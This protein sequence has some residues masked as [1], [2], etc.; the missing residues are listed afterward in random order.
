MRKIFQLMLFLCIYPL[1]AQ[2]IGIHPWMLKYAELTQ[3]LTETE[4]DSKWDG[5]L[6]QR[7]KLL[8]SVYSHYDKRS[9]NDEVYPYL[10]LSLIRSYIGMGDGKSAVKI[11]TNALR[12]I[13]NKD[14]ALA[15]T[16]EQI[17][18]YI[19]NGD[20]DLAESLYQD[21]RPQIEEVLQFFDKNPE[22]IE[23]CNIICNYYNAQQELT[24]HY[25][26]ALNSYQE[27]QQYETGKDVLYNKKD[28]FTN[29]FFDF[30]TLQKINHIAERYGLSGLDLTSS[31][32]TNA[33]V[34]YYQQM[35][36]F[37]MKTG[38]YADASSYYYMAE[39]Y[40]DKEDI[41]SR[42]SIA[43]IYLLSARYLAQI[44][45]YQ[46][47]D[48]YYTKCI[49]ICANSDDKDSLDLMNYS[50]MELAE[51]KA[52]CGQFEEANDYMSMLMDYYGKKDMIATVDFINLLWHYNTVLSRARRYKESCDICQEALY[53]LPR[54]ADLDQNR[55]KT[56]FNNSLAASLSHLQK[57]NEAIECLNNI[58]PQYY[59]SNTY[60]TKAII[61][62][63]LG[64]YDDAI[65]S[66]YECLKSEEQDVPSDNRLSVYSALLATAIEA[67]KPID[68]HEIADLFMSLYASISEIS[69][70][71]D[72]HYLIPIYQI[73]YEMFLSYCRHFNVDIDVAYNQTLCFKGAILQSEA[74]MQNKIMLS[75]DDYV[76][77]RYNQIKQLEQRI[78]H[79]ISNHETQQL[80]SQVD[81][82]EKE[83]IHRLNSVEN[84]KMDVNWRAVSQGLTRNEVAIELVNYICPSESVEYAALILRK[85]W[86]APKMIPLCKKSDLEPLITRLQGIYNNRTHRDSAESYIYKRLYSFVWSKLEP[87]IN[88]GDNVYFSPSGLLHQL[89]IEVLKDAAGRQ[90]NEKWNLHRV[91]STRKLCMDRPAIKWETAALYGGLVYDMDL[92]A[93]LAQSRAYRSASDYRASRGFVA[94]STERGSW[95]QL[96]NTVRE[97][98]AI[99]G[100]LRKKRIKSAKYMQYVGTE[101]SFKS[102]YGKGTSIIHLAT[103]GFF[104]KDEEAKFKPFFELH[105]IDQF[106][107]RPDNSLKRSGLI[108]AGGQRAWL[109]QPIPNRVE[110]GILLAEEIAAM[111]LSGTDLV[112]L[113]AC[114]TGLGEITSEGVFG[115]QRA[116]KKAGV[117]TLIMS[118]WRVDDAATSLMMRTFYEHLLASKSK[119]EAFAIAQLA[120]KSEYKDP[121]YWASFIM[122]D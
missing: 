56:Y 8:D 90:A 21:I 71:S 9:Y 44:G 66:L 86:D 49:T 39:S 103:H 60:F 91:S 62:Y 3:Q 57:Y 50:A 40:C 32:I 61:Q 37:C 109:G 54:V 34:F 115:L 63:G 7:T 96:P 116:F 73:Y 45:N 118:L 26:Y 83:I 75:K 15:F 46:K 77:D 84:Q 43:H 4:D 53:I 64:M 38:Q 24:T 6:Q 2:E 122:L 68:V 20:I 27:K 88:E 87:Y 114:E 74:D 10:S 89:N 101:E 55:Y 25:I 94:D 100:L 12:Q 41:N 35:G 22:S 105:N 110:D 95:A 51:I 117:R 47:A 52:I 119:R 23:S 70:S 29:S 92:T 1:Y 17:R 80:K 42:Y 76:I 30:R 121:Y 72:K 98:N 33:K 112:V 99:D 69:T 78:T 82:I 120:V 113:S 107:Y 108:L 111:D 19:L 106:K 11:Y 104:Y 85:D 65:H 18:I 59:T 58:K 79:S 14:Y 93:M 16:V 5:I 97:I 67:G 13:K 28:L 81:D 31:D 48:D 102:L 36:F